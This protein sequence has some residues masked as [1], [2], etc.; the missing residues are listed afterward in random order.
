MPPAPKA[1]M[2]S[3]PAAGVWLSEPDERQARLAEA[4]HMDRMANAVARPA[5]PHAEAPTGA[6]QK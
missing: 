3:D 4:L 1:S 5:V 6:A 2:P